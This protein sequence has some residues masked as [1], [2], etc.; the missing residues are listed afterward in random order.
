MQLLITFCIDMICT[1]NEFLPPWNCDFHSYPWI[2]MPTKIDDIIVHVLILLHNLETIIYYIDFELWIWL[3]CVQARTTSFEK[4]YKPGIMG[5]LFFLSENCNTRKFLEKHL[6][7]E[8]RIN[9]TLLYIQRHMYR[10]T[11]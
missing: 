7:I 6:I 3:I 11:P 1:A 10:H 5:H 9:D 4:L 8:Y 2:L